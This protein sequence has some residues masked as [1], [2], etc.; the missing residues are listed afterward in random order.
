[1]AIAR[2]RGATAEDHPDEPVPAALGGGDEET[3]E[4]SIIA[5]EH[6]AL[7][8]ALAPG[9]D[10]DPDEGFSVE[11]FAWAQA[12]T[13]IW[14]INRR[15]KNWLIPDNMLDSLPIWEEAT[16][17]RPSSATTD[18]ERRARVAAKL[19]GLVSNAIGFIE[20]AAQQTLGAAFDGLVLVDP[21]EFVVYWPGVNPGPPGF[22]WSTNRVR[23]G[24]RVDPTSLTDLRFSEVRQVLFDQLDTMIPGWMTFQIGV[25]SSFT[26]NQGI[27]GQTFI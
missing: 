5:V 4:G 20:S 23:I 7:L 17:L 10:T 26:I 25:G 6:Q 27:I 19:L 22:E 14:A 2:P 3:E 13:M 11:M 8:D 12:V 24:I 9:W 15:M 18:T 16:G 21:S 1:M